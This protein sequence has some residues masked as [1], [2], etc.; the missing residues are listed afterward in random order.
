MNINEIVGL[1]SGPVIGAV[2][3]YFTNYIAVK[4][5]FKPHKP[6]MIGKFRVPFTPGIIPKRRS[7]MAEEIGRAVGKHLLTTEDFEKILLSDDV[8]AKVVQDAAEVWQRVENEYS[9][10]SLSVHLAG[11]AKTAELKAKIQDVVTARLLYNVDKLPIG[12]MVVAKATEVAGEKIQG[13]LLAKFVSQDKINSMIA[14]IGPYVDEYLAENGQ[15]IFEPMVKDEVTAL[16]EMPL[17]EVQQK[18]GV[19]DEK[20]ASVIEKVY[21]KFVGQ[22][23]ADVIENISVAEIVSE[24]INNM[25]ITEIE[26]MVLEVMQKELRAI[27][28]LGALIGFVIGFLTVL[29]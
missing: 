5:L 16:S 10:Q 26:R 27:V 29:F 21:E 17:A 2:I 11:E 24:R 15:D 1:L 23:L 7:A 13:T 9:A 28:N 14:P 25:E 22:K 4:M 19:T 18:L 6:I 20:I 8:K 12:D 3:G